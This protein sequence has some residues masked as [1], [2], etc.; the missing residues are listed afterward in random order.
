MLETATKTSIVSLAQGQLGMEIL[1]VLVWLVELSQVH[2]QSQPRKKTQV[3]KIHGNNAILAC[4]VKKFS[5]IA[6]CW[7]FNSTSK[8]YNCIY[9]EIAVYFL[10]TVCSLYSTNSIAAITKKVWREFAWMRKR[11]QMIKL[12]STAHVHFGSSHALAEQ[13]CFCGSLSQFAQTSHKIKAKQLNPVLNKTHAFILIFS[14]G[15]CSTKLEGTRPC[16][17]SISSPM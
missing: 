5:T 11:I 8:I 3:M 1:Q 7:E 17:P 16:R 6:T 12:Q 4:Y 2:N 14:P 9:S 15:T 10:K 13:G